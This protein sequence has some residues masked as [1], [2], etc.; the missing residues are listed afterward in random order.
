[1]QIVKVDTPLFQ[2]QIGI[3]TTKNRIIRKSFSSQEM[4]LDMQYVCF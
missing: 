1:M 2:T 3:Y 4:N